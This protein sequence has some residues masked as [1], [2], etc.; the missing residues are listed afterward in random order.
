MSALIG[1][2]GRL[3]SWVPGFLSFDRSKKTTSCPHRPS[4][5]FSMDQEW[6]LLSNTGTDLIH[7]MGSIDGNVF[8]GLN[9]AKK[10]ERG[11]GARGGGTGIEQRGAPLPPP[12]PRVRRQRRWL[13]TSNLAPASP[14]TPPT[15]PLQNL[16]GVRCAW[17]AEL[18]SAPTQR[19]HRAPPMGCGSA[20]LPT[21]G[22]FQAL[23]AAAAPRGAERCVAGHPPA[24]PG[25]IVDLQ[26]KLLCS[27]MS[28]RAALCAKIHEK[29]VVCVTVGW[30]GGMLVAFPLCM[31]HTLILTLPA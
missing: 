4:P 25:L 16:S 28:A 21:G 22:K 11:S 10:R 13:G 18:T 20:G 14:R 8:N 23:A 1:Q 12:H 6:V 15:R 31:L 7:Q 2:S 24:Q 19:R 29:P 3:L 27:S 30:A 9:R 26:P 5:L 17:L